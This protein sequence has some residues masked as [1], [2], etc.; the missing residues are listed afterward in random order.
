LP[1][2]PCKSS[3]NGLSEIVGSEL[4]SRAGTS[5]KQFPAVKPVVISVGKPPSAAASSA[6]LP[7]SLLSSAMTFLSPASAHGYLC[8]RQRKKPDLCKRNGVALDLEAT[9]QPTKTSKLAIR[10]QTHMYLWNGCMSCSFLTP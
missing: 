1:K 7:S 8:K 3:T 10:N 5:S 4:G 2:R 6:A 9:N